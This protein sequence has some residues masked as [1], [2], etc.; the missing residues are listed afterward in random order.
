MMLKI[1][2]IAILLFFILLLVA[3]VLAGDHISTR[4]ESLLLYINGGAWHRSVS[5]Y[6]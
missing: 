1:I 6:S 2:K 3:G 4:I 5:E